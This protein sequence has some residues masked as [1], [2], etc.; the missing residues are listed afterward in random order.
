M[1]NTT[2][3]HQV[4]LQ[5]MGVFAEY[6]INAGGFLKRPHFFRVRDAYF[7]RGLNQALANGWIRSH[8]RDRY[9][10]FLTSAGK[11]ACDQ[12]SRTA[13]IVVPAQ[14]EAVPVRFDSDLVGGGP[15][16]EPAGR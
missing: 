10:Y 15:T 7:Q 5:I 1:T 12:L 16:I 8:E 13:G 3:D 6:K 14:L 2:I 9:R 11:A 4:A